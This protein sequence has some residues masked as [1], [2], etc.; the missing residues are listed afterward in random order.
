MNKP[1]FGKSGF[2]YN[3][4]A[5]ENFYDAFKKEH[6][7]YAHKTWKEVVEAWANISEEFR[8]QIAKNPLGVKLKYYIGELKFQYVPYKFKVTRTNDRQAPFRELNLHNRGKVGVFKWERRAAVRYNKW[9]Q[10]YGF[11]PCDLLKKKGKEMI[12][13]HPDAIRTCRITTGRKR[14]R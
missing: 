8:E 12:E 13:E 6:P 14:Q 3:L 7:E 10:Y 9:L 2:I 11:D 5:K 1:R 4:L